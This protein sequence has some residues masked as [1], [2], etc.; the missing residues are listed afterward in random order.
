LRKGMVMKH[1][2]AHNNRFTLRARWALWGSGWLGHSPVAH[3][4][5]SLHPHFV[6]PANTTCLLIRA[7]KTS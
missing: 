6:G 4:H 2:T 1:S 5:A 7:A 3:F